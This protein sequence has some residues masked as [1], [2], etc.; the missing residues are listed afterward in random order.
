[1]TTPFLA[2][3]ELRASDLTAAVIRTAYASSNTTKISSTAFGDAAGMAMALEANTIY[4]WDCYLA[5]DS[6]LTPDIKIAWTAPAGATG[7][8][9][10]YGLASTTGGS[11]I[12]DLSALRVNAYGDAS[13]IALGGNE[14]PSTPGPLVARPMGYVEVGAT[15]GNLQLRFAQNSSNATNTIIRAGSWLRAWKLA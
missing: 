11:G 7:H 13:P 8:W 1:M 9:G 6:G 10:A 3:Q 15:A 5:Y 12:G 2:G 4:G 14:I